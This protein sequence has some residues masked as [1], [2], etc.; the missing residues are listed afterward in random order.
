MMTMEKIRYLFQERAAATL[1]SQTPRKGLAFTDTRQ[2]ARM[3]LRLEAQ[4]RG[5]GVAP[6]EDPELRAQERVKEGR[7]EEAS[8]RQ[9]D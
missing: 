2:I 7:L 4:L 6:R 5:S 3:M 8:P 1:N 9:L